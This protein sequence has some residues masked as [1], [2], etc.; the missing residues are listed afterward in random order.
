MSGQ[1]SSDDV[2]YNTIISQ[3]GTSTARLP[4][5]RGGGRSSS[6]VKCGGNPKVGG[7]HFS[8]V[9]LLSRSYKLHGSPRPI[10][11]WEHPLHFDGL[12]SN[13][14]ERE[15]KGVAGMAATLSFD[16]GTAASILLLRFLPLAV[17]AG[18]PQCYGKP[19][20][21]RP[22][23]N[24]KLKVK[25]TQFPRIR[26]VHGLGL[27]RSRGSQD[28]SKRSKSQTTEV[29]GQMKKSHPG[30]L[31]RGDKR[32]VYDVLVWLGSQPLPTA[33]DAYAGNDAIPVFHLFPCWSV[34]GGDYCLTSLLQGAENY[35]FRQEVHTR[36]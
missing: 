35:R 8:Q 3:T 5:F 6:D 34:G 19:P 11:G 32:L 4:T 12:P 2:V 23:T 13:K 30:F 21:S 10:V 36:C 9:Y 29:D 26:V 20:V 28:E 22:R 14:H 18:C 17:T 16:G 31:R 24:L 15:R 25:L 1:A 27:N 7:L 33:R